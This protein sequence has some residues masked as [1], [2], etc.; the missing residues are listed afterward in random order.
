MDNWFEHNEEVCAFA[1]ALVNGDSI[2]GMDI[3]RFF[4]TPWDYNEE[5]AAWVAA[6]RPDAFETEYDDDGHFVAGEGAHL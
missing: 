1:R 2:R 5:R 6:G 4:E 3:V